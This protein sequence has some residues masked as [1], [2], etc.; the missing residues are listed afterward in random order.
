MSKILH[1]MA[2]KTIRM[3]RIRHILRLFTQGQSRKKISELTATSRNTV[4][5]YIA[6]FIH[7]H[8]TFDVINEMSDHEL[9]AMFGY[10]EPMPKDSRHEDAQRFLKGNEKHLRRKGTSVY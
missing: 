7:E 1:Q 3:S 6:R 5:K 4:K 9:D 8:L 2:N 10:V